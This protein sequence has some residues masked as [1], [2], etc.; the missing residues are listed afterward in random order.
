MVA[1]HARRRS[2]AHRTRG[3]IP[4]HSF[5]AGAE[6]AE[7]ETVVPVRSIDPSADNFA[8]DLR[9]SIRSRRNHNDDRIDRKVGLDSDS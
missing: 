1:A 3:R 8:A 9:Q 2:V 4:T 6:M 5:L 7:A